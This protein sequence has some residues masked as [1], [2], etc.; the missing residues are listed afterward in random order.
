MIV[1]KPKRRWLQ[2]SLRTL[3]LAITFFAAWLAFYY[4][5]GKR[6]ERAAKA[7]EQIGASVCYDYQRVAG[8]YSVTKPKPGPAFLHAILGDGLLQHAEFVELQRKNLKVGELAPLDYLTTIQNLQIRECDLTDEHLVHIAGLR[9]LTVLLL[10]D[11]QITDQ[12][13]VNLAKLSGLEQLQISNNQIHGSGLKYL[14]GLTNLKHL[15]LF[16]NPISDDGLENLASLKNLESLGFSDANITDDGLSH[17]ANLKK[18]KYLNVINT[19][20]TRAGA[21][22]LNAA[23]PNCVINPFFSEDKYPKAK[24]SDPIE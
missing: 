24:S 18:L 19:K 3:M 11:G 2:F 7:L 15:I 12:G 6:A 23:L 10:D 13:L 16:N 1:T 9:Q 5:S 4:L 14:V 8:G 21:A 17:L 22:K 20:V